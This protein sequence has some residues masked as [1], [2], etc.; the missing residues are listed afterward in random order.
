[1]QQEREM[2][3]WKSPLLIGVLVLLSW[4]AQAEPG[5]TD[6]SITFGMSA[7]FSG[8][9]GAYGQD[10]KEAIAT[11]FEQVNK[12]GGVHG[13]KLELIALDDGYEA[14]RTVAN[15]KSLV[16]DKKV[17][18][19][20]AFYGSSP[21]TEAMN[22][23]FGP[24]RVPLVGAI[25]GATTLR[26]AFS[27]NPN[28]RYVFNI[29]ASYADEAEAII[30]QLVALGLTRIAVLYQNDGFGKSG[31]DGISAALRKNGLAPAAVG[32]VERNSL[33]VGKAVE[34]IAKA[35]PQ[36]VVMV[37]LYKPTAAFVKAMKKAGHSPLFMTLSSVGAEQLVQELGNEARGI[38]ISQV[39]PYPWNDTI[40]LVREYQ[41]L[42]GKQG[43]F[44][45]YGVEGYLMARV[46][47]DALKKQGKEPTREKLVSTLEAMNQDLGGY[48]VKFSPEAHAG[49][50]F[51]ELTVIGPGGRVLK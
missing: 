26:Q 1:M 10:M 16:E 44:S 19:L 23:V 18:G 24:A 36:A 27:E 17:F 34:S 13:R 45:Y 33:E 28:T 9:N 12:G 38:G 15:T 51:V 46:L 43:K 11:Y 2:K 39:M 6:T 48:R 35:M 42:L 21:T 4:T 22:A 7:P 40:P 3:T 31:L 47:V 41:H 50:K 25:S 14:E 30:K 20:L 32:T 49:S 37:T 5:V 29:R 8:P